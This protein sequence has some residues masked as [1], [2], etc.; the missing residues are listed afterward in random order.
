MQN[1]LSV[2]ISSCDK[3]S[4]LWDEN[5]KAYRKFWLQ[6]PCATYLVTDAKKDWEADGVQLVV[7]EGENDFPLRIKYALNCVDTKYVLVTLDDYFLI[8][9]VDNDKI[10][11]LLQR[12]E[13]EHIQYLSL[14][15]RRVTKP[16]QYLPLEKLNRIDLTKKYAIT[17]YPAIW[18][19]EFLKKTIQDD[20]SPWL[21]EVSLT[22]TAVQ[23]NANC[24]SSLA[25]T[26]N[27]LDVVRKGKVL[28]K[29][30]RY[31]KRHQIDI[32]SR[33][34]ISY[35]TE[36]KLFILDVVSWYMPR[37]LFKAVKSTARKCGMTFYSED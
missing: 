10:E 18:E 2:V 29:A 36:A 32:G 23:E 34:S 11:Y 17:L 25:G 24:Q 35:A 27:I 26:Y 19:V 13:N 1:K 5:I 9:P 6:N 37:K 28:H 3:F 21:Y 4:D 14:Y 7:A 22:K 30:Q 33:P 12:M 8:D 16:K 20:L 15:N 31:F